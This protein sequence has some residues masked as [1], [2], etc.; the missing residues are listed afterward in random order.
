[1]GMAIPYR[2][3]QS[4]NVDKQMLAIVVTALN[5]ALARDGAGR[6]LVVQDLSKLGSTI[7][8]GFI[9]RILY[10]AALCTTKIAICAFYRRVFQD[11]WSKIFV[12]TMMGIVTAFTVPLIIGAIFQCKPIEGIYLPTELFIR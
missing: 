4:A 11:R 6:H 5:L 9:G 12:Y 10:L 7:L 2:A 3:V 8:L 1:M